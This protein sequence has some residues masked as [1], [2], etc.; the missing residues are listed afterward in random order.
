MRKLNEI[1][2][3][4]G[5]GARVTGRSVKRHLPEI[6]FVAAVGCIIKGVAEGYK[7][8][9]EWNDCLTSHM[10]ILDSISEKAD[11]GEITAQEEVSQ[12]V[13]EWGSITLD[14]LKKNGKCI[15]FTG[16]GI[17]AFGFDFHY[18]KKENRSLQKA[19]FDSALLT[20]AYRGRVAD[21]V[22]KEKEY[23]LFH[24]IKRE[25]VEEEYTDENGKKKKRTVEKV[26]TSEATCGDHN[27]FFFGEGDVHFNDMASNVAFLSQTEEMLNRMIVGRG[28]Y[29]AM[30]RAEI[31]RFF[32]HDNKDPFVAE[33][34]RFGCVYLKSE[35][36]AGHYEHPYADPLLPRVV[37]LTTSKEF[38]E[39]TGETWIDINCYPID[40]ILEKKEKAL[41]SARRGGKYISTI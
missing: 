36:E 32:K 34:Q 26:D 17:A 27:S 37:K 21:F 25:M 14:F 8:S 29:G 3:T 40:P 39:T 24:N 22:G 12:T 28:D 15:F 7:A 16:A 20:A 4:I 11:E 18:L 6:I 31:F 9:P 13:K 19:L 41:I 23:D 2:S 38:G 10:D 33:S 30:T 35:D 1:T 5:N